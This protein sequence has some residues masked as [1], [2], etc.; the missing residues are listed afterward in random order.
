MQKQDV[1][2]MQHAKIFIFVILSLFVVSQC[3]SGFALAEVGQ[4]TASAAIKNAEDASTSAFQAV[5]KAGS[6]GANVSAFLSQLNE[7]GGFLAAANVDFRLG[8]YTETVRLAN[9]SYRLCYNVGSQAHVLQ[10]ATQ[11]Q[12]DETVNLSLILSA[13]SVIVI[14]IASFLAWRFFKKSYYKR[15]LLMKPEGVPDEP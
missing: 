10:L 8:N 9:L 4:V 2:Q 11:T 15:A 13:A 14:N 12:K 5:I 6:L 7:A 3:E 1:N